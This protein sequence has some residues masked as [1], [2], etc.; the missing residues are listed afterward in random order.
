MLKEYVYKSHRIRA[1]AIQRLTKWHPQLTLAGSV[2]AITESAE[3]DSEKEAVA[4]AC[5]HGEF[6][7]DHPAQTPVPAD[8]LWIH[9]YQNP[10]FERGVFRVDK[11]EGGRRR[12]VGSMKIDEF[13]G[14]ISMENV[15][16]MTVDEAVRTLERRGKVM[17]QIEA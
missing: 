12:P 5:A 6:L 9:A 13:R 8:K 4:F 17:V 2:Q 3:L 15:L 1:T 11:I 14:Y 7:V 16:N 10:M